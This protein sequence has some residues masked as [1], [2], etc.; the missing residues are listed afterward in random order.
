MLLPLSIFG[1]LLHFP[2]YQLCKLAAHLFSRHGADDVA[3][4]VKVLAGMVFFPL[5]WLFTAA[6]LYFL[7]G[8]W[9]LAIASIPFS[10][11]AGYI[12]LYSWEE[13]TEMSGWARAIW[14]FLLRKER[15]LRLFVER[16]ELQEQLKEID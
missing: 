7:S 4:T 5:T 12:T 10:F 6:I 9:P 13:A 8:S 3:S 2:A 16:R 1:T 15:F 11:V 14:H